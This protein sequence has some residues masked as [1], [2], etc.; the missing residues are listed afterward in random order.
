MK[1]ERKRW[2]NKEKWN[3]KEMEERLKRINKHER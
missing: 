1:S 3:R 2:S